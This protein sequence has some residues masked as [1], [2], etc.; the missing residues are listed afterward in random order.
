M[1]PA[2]RGF[3]RGLAAPGVIYHLRRLGVTA[4]DLLPI[5]AFAD[6]RRLIEIGLKNYWGY[7]TLC[8]FAPEPRYAPDNAN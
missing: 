6:D 1:P 7:N 3:F 2:W 4:I 5:H 8:F